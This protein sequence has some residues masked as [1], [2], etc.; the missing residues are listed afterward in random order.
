M[1]QQNNNEFDIA[2]LLL[3]CFCPAFA[4]PLPAGRR[5]AGGRQAA[6]R[7]Q[8]GSTFPEEAIGCKSEIKIAS[9]DKERQDRNDANMM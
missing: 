6:G 1:I 8:A 2:S 5:Q 3:P 4:L 7:R 9:P